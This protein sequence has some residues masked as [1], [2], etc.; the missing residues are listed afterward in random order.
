MYHSWRSAHT[1]RLMSSNQA[2]HLQ[3]WLSP[4]MVNIKSS[5]PLFANNRHMP[6]IMP[7]KDA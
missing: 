7:E 4:P 6:E 5:T 1:P 3:N 2:C